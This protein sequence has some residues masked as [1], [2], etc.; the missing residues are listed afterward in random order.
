MANSNR[1]TEVI[2]S[3]SRHVAVIGAGMAGISAARV[4]QA[5]GLRV[6]VVDK[7]RKPGGRMATRR[8]QDGFFDHGAQFVKAKSESFQQVLYEAKSAGVMLPWKPKEN[9]AREGGKGRRGSRRNGGGAGHGRRAGGERT[10]ASKRE[11]YAGSDGMRSLV[12]YLARDIDVRVSAKVTAISGRPAAYQL[13]LE[14][15]DRLGPFAAVLVTAPTLQAIPLFDGADAPK[16]AS[17]LAGVRYSPCWAALAAFEADATYE[18]GLPIDFDLYRGDDKLALAARNESKVAPPVSVAE[19]ERPSLSRWTL[20]ASAAASTQWLEL[21]KQ[22]VA[23]RLLGRFSELTAAPLPAPVHVDAHRWLYAKVEAAL[24]EPCLF[25]SECLLGY[26]G[27]G[28]LGSRVECAYE[29]GT[30][31]ASRVLSRLG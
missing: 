1:Q 6:S 21:S 9:D 17:A 8:H 18:K 13:C 25:D 4:L 23:K 27:D 24:G 15:G 16:L 12:T 5:A 3:V 7:G 29:S 31:L 26:A 14:D 20:H 22:D 2:G 10:G 30:A 28:C 19:G 11:V